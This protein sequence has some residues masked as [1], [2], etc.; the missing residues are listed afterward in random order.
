MAKEKKK[1]KGP[2]FAG[3]AAWAVRKRFKEGKRQ[4]PKFGFGIDKEA[5]YKTIGH[6][7]HKNGRKDSGLI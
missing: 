1:K 7:S 3:Q 6:E 5:G 4:A 2:S